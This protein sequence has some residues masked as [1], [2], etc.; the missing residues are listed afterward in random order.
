MWGVFEEVAEGGGEGEVGD[1]GGEEEARGGGE[2][3]VFDPFEG[4]DCWVVY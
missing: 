3:V 2:C 1:D 4:G